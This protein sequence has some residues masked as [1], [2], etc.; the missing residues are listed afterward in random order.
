M[1]FRHRN[2]QSY[3]LRLRDRPAQIA[4]SVGLWL[5]TLKDSRRHAARIGDQQRPSWPPHVTLSGRCHSPKSIG[6]PKQGDIMMGV[7]WRGDETETKTALRHVG[8]TV[9]PRDRE[10]FTKSEKRLLSASGSAIGPR[11]SRSGGPGRHGHHKYEEDLLGTAY[12]EADGWQLVKRGHVDADQLMGVSVGQVEVR[13]AVEVTPPVGGAKAVINWA[14]LVGVDN[15]L[16]RPRGLEFQSP[17]EEY[18]VRDA[19]ASCIRRHAADGPVVA[20]VLEPSP[21][22]IG[23]SAAVYRIRGGGA[24]PSDHVNGRQGTMPYRRRS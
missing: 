1:I 13:V 10:C 2:V 5:R 23:Q 3:V 22:V 14:A 20:T 4:G 15:L 16:R 24:V 7:R 21:P 6:V 8:M 12:Q 9:R 11:R 19:V 18:T 17:H